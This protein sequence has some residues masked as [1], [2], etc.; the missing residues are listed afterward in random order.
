MDVHR[1][2]CEVAIAD[3]GRASSAGRVVTDPEQLELFAQ[4]LGSDDRVVLA[5]AGN[6]L[7]IALAALP[8]NLKRR[9]PV[10]DLFGVRGRGWLAEQELPIDER[11]TV[12]GCLRQLDFLGEELGQVDR[13]IAERALADA[14]VL[15]LLTIPGNRRDDREHAGGGDRRR[16]AVPELAAPGRL[17]GAAPDRPPV[18]APSCPPRPGVEGGLRRCPSRTGRAGRS[19]LPPNGQRPAGH[20]SE[21]GAGA[22]P[23]RIFKA[24]YAASSAAD[25]RA[26]TVCA[27]AR[28]SPAP[29][30]TLAREVAASNASLLFIRKSSA[31]ASSVGRWRLRPPGARAPPLRSV[32][33]A[34]TRAAAPTTGGSCNSG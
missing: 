23:G 6:A 10:S 13:V 17:S 18:R 16:R 1:D 20:G 15:R 22:T 26:P 30:G 24:V 31:P 11:L 34:A 12:D 19:G 21:K 5:A 27:L 7:A 33:G 32:V 2:F 4:S 28:R 25:H 9:P 3:G 14:D 29:T 8:R